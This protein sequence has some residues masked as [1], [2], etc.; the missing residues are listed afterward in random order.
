MMLVEYYEHCIFFT[1]RY[2]VFVFISFFDVFLMLFFVY[3]DVNNIFLFL[4]LGF[5]L[6]PS[7]IV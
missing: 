6:L 4:N 5:Q 1:E 7:K 2:S 3:Y